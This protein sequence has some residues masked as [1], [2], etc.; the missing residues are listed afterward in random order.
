MSGAATHLSSSTAVS[1]PS[2]ASHVV[3][4]P[5]RKVAKPKFRKNY[6]PP[7]F[8]CKE[9]QLDFDLFDIGTKVTSRLTLYR[10]ENGTAPLLLDGAENLRLKSVALNKIPLWASSSTVNNKYVYNLDSQECTLQIDGELLP[11]EKDVDFVVEVEVEHDPIDNLQLMGL[12][13]SGNLFCT[14]CEAEGFRRI[15]YFLDRPDVMAIYKVR[16]TG[17]LKECG[18]LLSNGNQRETGVDPANPTTRHFAVFEDPFPKPCYLFAVV[19]GNLASID[20]PFKTMSGRN[21]RLEVFSESQDV[22]R[23]SWALDSLVMAMKW[24]EETFGREYDLDV[25]N[26]VSVKDFNMGAMENKGLNI[27]NAALLLADERTST[28]HEFQRV[29]NVVAHEYFHNWTG[30]RV[31]CRDWFEL[32]LKEGL[33]VYRDQLFT[34]QVAGRAVKRIEDVT[35]IKT[36]QFSEDSGPMTH[37]IRPESYIAMDNF[38]TATVYDKG[39]EVIGMY[40]TLL[41]VNGFRK[42]LDLYFQ[43]HDGQAATCDNFRSAMADANGVDLEQFGQ[44][45]PQNGTPEVEVTAYDYDSSAKRVTLALQQGV[46]SVS[47]CQHRIPLH[48]LVKVGLLGKES[49]KDLL[50]EGSKILELRESRQT[51]TIENVPEEPVLSLL[52]DFSSPVRVRNPFQSDY[53]RCFLMAYDSDEFNKWE[54]AQTLAQDILLKRAEHLRGVNRSSREDLIGSL[55]PLPAMFVDAFSQCLKL[56]KS[57]D[58]SLQAYTLRLPA[59]EALHLEMTYPVNYEA[60]HEAVRSVANDLRTRLYPQFKSQ[61]DELSNIIA[62]REK[63]NKENRRDCR[64]YNRC[65]DQYLVGARRLRNLILHYLCTTTD[66]RVDVKPRGVEKEH[67]EEE[68]KKQEEEGAELAYQHLDRAYCMTDKMDALKCLC[69]FENSKLRDFAIHQFY[70]GAFGN[71]LVIDKWFTLQALSDRADCLDCVRSL[72]THPDFTIKNPNRLRSLIFAFT[73]NFSKF[74]VITGEGY[75]L[76]RKV[77][78]EVDKINPQIAARGC[79]SLINWKRVDPVRQELLKKELKCIL[80]TTGLSNDTREIVLKGLGNEANAGEEK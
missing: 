24:D 54:A 72:Q 70:E 32:T 76:L 31:T 61:Y 1:P 4:K 67:G 73:R 55:T 69:N 79:S 10:T 7:I 41:G 3:L 38:Y 17:D 53:D 78:V 14:Q 39:A 44:W 47:N 35:F 62:N 13:K 6:Q 71:P 52:R 36:K 15:T 28:D 56:D 23:L 12:Y 59:E 48:I 46:P 22:A 21:V 27:F 49:K 34:Q 16:L 8:K 18:S 9:V 29:L 11:P 42:G 37:P 68:A 45:Y 57:K 5:Q 58:M 65:L 20:R 40:S 2:C 51:F 66:R 80:N 25:F 33:T 63:E 26:L 30:N 77:I 19:A 75:E 60:I 50:P 74:H 64:G 43:R